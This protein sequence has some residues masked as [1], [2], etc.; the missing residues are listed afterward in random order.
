MQRERRETREFMVMVEN[1]LKTKNKII[2]CC[3]LLDNGEALIYNKYTIIALLILKMITQ[4]EKYS[5]SNLK[6]MMTTNEWWTREKGRKEI[7]INESRAIG[8][9]TANDCDKNWQTSGNNVCET[10]DR[11]SN[12]ECGHWRLIYTRE[13]RRRIFYAIREGQRAKGSDTY[14]YVLAIEESQITH[15]LTHTFLNWGDNLLM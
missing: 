9:F 1:S 10:G 3:D 8:I 15:S 7:K 6:Q 2:W 14:P 5:N 4:W 13:L 12:W 11:I